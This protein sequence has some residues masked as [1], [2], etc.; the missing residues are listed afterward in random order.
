[1]DDLLIHESALK[2]AIQYFGSEYTLGKAIGVTQQQVSYWVRL[3]TRI[4]YET[5]WRIVVATKGRIAIDA[6]R[7][8]LKTLN[9][10]VRQIML[11][12]MSVNEETG[13]LEVA[14]AHIIVDGHVR[15]RRKV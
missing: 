8:D 4:K 9:E 3:G 6:L 2:Q 15:K 1:M 14:V 13:D 11:E 7:S 12:D 5:A 10:Q